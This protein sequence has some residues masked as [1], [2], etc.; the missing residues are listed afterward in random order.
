M[1]TTTRRRSDRGATRR[2]SGKLAAYQEKRDF[3]RTP[4]PSGRGRSR[5]PK[6][7]HRF[8]VQRHRARRLHYDLRLEIG[9]VLVSGAVP[10]VPTLDPRARR[11]PPA[12]GVPAA[13]GLRPGPGLPPGP[14]GG[15][16]GGARPAHGGELR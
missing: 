16:G 11:F 3:G 14:A 15:S 12:A 5:A 1:A 10:K 13:G 6:G 8:V 7:G 9:G 2:P 4:E